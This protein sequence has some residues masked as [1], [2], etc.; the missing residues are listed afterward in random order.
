MLANFVLVLVFL[1]VLDNGISKC[2]FMFI[3]GLMNN[4]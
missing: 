2:L 3:S 1:L 4:K